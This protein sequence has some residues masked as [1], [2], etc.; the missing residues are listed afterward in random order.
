VTSQQILQMAINGLMLGLV[1][2]LIALGLTLV[3]GVMR[4][5]NFAHGELYMLGGFITYYL[6]GE[7]KLNFALTLI[8]SVFAMALL[9]VIIERLFLSRLRAEFMASFIVTLGVATFLQSAALLAFGLTEKGVPTVI[10]GVARFAGVSLSLERLMLIPVSLV[11]II[12]TALFV[13]KTR[14]GRAMQAVSSDP[15]AAALYGVNI[16]R[17]SSLCMAIGCA[18]AGAAGTLVA[19][20]FS[21]NPFMGE[22]P[23]FKGFIIIVVGG[24]GSIQGAL[25]AGIMLGCLEAFGTTMFGAPIAYIMSFLVL[26]GFLLFRPRGFFG[27]V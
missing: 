24:L 9:G 2:S 6:Y 21:V 13:Q 23:L 27:R 10:S 1:Y 15:E 12:A 3:F 11:L 4:I 26:I 8:V 22:D 18:L 17:T 5:V 16:A 20:I 19:P 7:W 25:L 14:A